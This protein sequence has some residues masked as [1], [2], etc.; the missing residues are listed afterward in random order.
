MQSQR[1]CRVTSLSQEDEDWRTSLVFIRSCFLECEWPGSR[2]TIYMQHACLSP[3][4]T[5]TNMLY[6]HC[7]CT[8]QE[9][10]LRFHIQEWW[11]ADKSDAVYGLKQQQHDVDKS[12]LILQLEKLFQ[13]TCSCKSPTTNPIVLEHNSKDAHLHLDVTRT[14]EVSLLDFF[15]ELSEMTYVRPLHISYKHLSEAVGIWPVQC[16]CMV[17]III[18]LHFASARQL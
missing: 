6:I 12:Y 14:W 9:F 2:R 7:T 3:V 15:F 16:H 8:Q 17:T 4:H 13:V 1:K 5:E 10:R 11:L 18:H